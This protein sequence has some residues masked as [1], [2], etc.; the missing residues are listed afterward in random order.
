MQMELGCVRCLH[1]KL[2]MA[3]LQEEHWEGALI[4]SRCHLVTIITILSAV[5]V[6][7][8]DTHLAEVS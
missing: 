4:F 5:A 1:S 7:R 3:Q 2:A 8:N 6:S